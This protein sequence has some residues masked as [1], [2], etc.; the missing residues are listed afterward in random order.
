MSVIPLPPGPV[1]DRT[2]AGLLRIDAPGLGLLCGL[3]RGLAVEAISI[4]DVSWRDSFDVLLVG[5]PMPPKE[6]GAPLAPVTLMASE[7]RGDDGQIVII[8]WFSHAPEHRWELS[9]RAALP[10]EAEG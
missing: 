5:K 9:R 3:P 10:P 7:T 4:D 8:A 6:P 2:R 1:V